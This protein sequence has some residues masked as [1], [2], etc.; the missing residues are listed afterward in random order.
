MDRLG[1]ID[2][3]KLLTLTAL[4]AKLQTWHYLATSTAQEGAVRCIFSLSFG[5]QLVCDH[6]LNAAQHHTLDLMKQ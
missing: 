4:D 6:R 2:T 1:S 3:V 5:W